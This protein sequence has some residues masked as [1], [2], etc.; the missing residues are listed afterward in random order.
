[1]MKNSSRLFRL[2]IFIY[3]DLFALLYIGYLWATAFIPTKL[4]L[5]L[6]LEKLFCYIHEKFIVAKIIISSWNL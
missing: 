6:L 1:M 3:F 5:Q 2:T 4:E